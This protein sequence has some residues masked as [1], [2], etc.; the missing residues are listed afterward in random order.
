MHRLLPPSAR[1]MR[2]LPGVTASAVATTLPMTGSDIGMGFTS[3]APGRSGRAYVGGVLRRQPGLLLDDGHPARARAAASPSAT[4]TG[5]PA[6][7]SSTRRW[8]RST[9]RARIALGKRVTI[10]YNN[11]GPREIV[12][13]V[14]DVKQSELTEARGAAD[15][16]AVRADAVAVSCGRRRATTAAPEAAAALAA[17][18]R[19]RASTRSRPPAKSGRSISTSARSIA[20][21]RFTAILVGAFAGAGAAA[22]R[23]RPLRRDGVFG[24]AAAPRDRHPHGA[25]R[26]GRPTSRSLVVGQAL[27]IGA[28]GP[29]DRPGRRAGR[30]AR[31]RQ[32][33]V[34]R[35]AERSG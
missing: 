33:A 20:T 1:R 18:R 22:G 6:S 11:T 17:R 4:T 10:S 31:A 5:A 8:R 34:R 35:Q 28:L 9:G 14:G 29:G 32:P 7:S 30:D 12:G 23:L 13:I 25:R 2:A 24:R 21:P 3:R 19:W 16:H 27:R 15:V 26:A